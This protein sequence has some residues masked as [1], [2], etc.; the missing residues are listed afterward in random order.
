MTPQNMLDAV[1]SIGIENTEKKPFWIGTGFIVSR[2]NSANPKQIFFYLIT[3]KHVVENQT[4]IIIRLNKMS[5]ELY[6][7]CKILLIDDNKKK[8]YSEHPN[9]STDVIACLIDPITLFN[10]KTVW[11]AFDLDKQ[12]LTLEQM[13]KEGLQEGSLVYS[14]GFPMGIVDIIKTPIFRLG[15]ISRFRDAYFKRNYYPK[16]YVDAQT[17]PGN[18]GGPII[19]RQEITISDGKPKILSSYLIGILSEYIQYRD[20]LYSSQDGEVRMILKENSGI[21]VVHPAD[22]IKEV[23]ELEFNRAHG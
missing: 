22:R 4:K 5:E 2:V 11:Q 15:C 6:D 3:N 8:L 19:N 23:V 16:Y 1:V 14:L 10:D 17:F 20:E 7:D 13:K 21:T 12:A 9:E 18:S